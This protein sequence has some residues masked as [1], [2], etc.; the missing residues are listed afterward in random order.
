[1]LSWAIGHKTVALL[2]I[3]PPKAELG[4]G[5]GKD[6]DIEVIRTS[7]IAEITQLLSFICSSLP[8]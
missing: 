1:M 2:L 7:Y 8:V 6:L 4:K 5:R 3:K